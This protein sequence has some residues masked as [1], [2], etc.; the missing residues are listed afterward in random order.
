MIVVVVVVVLSAALAL[1]DVGHPPLD[2]VVEF[3][4]AQMGSDS[5]KGFCSRSPPEQNLQVNFRKADVEK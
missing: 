3:V 5:A 2:R 4:D 1:A